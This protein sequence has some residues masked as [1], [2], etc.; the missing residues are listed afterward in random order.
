M[1]PQ[2]GPTG[3]EEPFPVSSNRFFR[4]WFRFSETGQQPVPSDEYTQY[5]DDE[6]Q[7]SQANQYCYPHRV[8]YSYSAGIFHSNFISL[9]GA[10]SWHSAPKTDLLSSVSGSSR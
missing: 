7:H 4:R 8:E 1:F 9:D 5:N 6:T 3:I 2:L 10:T